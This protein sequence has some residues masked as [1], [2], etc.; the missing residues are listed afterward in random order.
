M[1]LPLWH[2]AWG[3]GYSECA[4]IVKQVNR[5]VDGQM[6]DWADVVVSGVLQP[7]ILSLMHMQMVVCREAIAEAC[8]SSQ[9]SASQ[10]FS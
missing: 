1:I 7:P 6:D 9:F 3:L 2:P 8:L 5:G 4:V 10:S